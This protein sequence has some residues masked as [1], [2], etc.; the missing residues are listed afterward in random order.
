MNRLRGN[1]S[2]EEL[3]RNY[4]NCLDPIESKRWRLLWQVS[5]SKTVREA[6]KVLQMDYDYALNIVR[7]YNQLGSKAFSHH[8]RLN[9]FIHSANQT[10]N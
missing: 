10:P 5:Q 1:L 3:K 6:A 8:R 7:R 9:K 2:E 4:T